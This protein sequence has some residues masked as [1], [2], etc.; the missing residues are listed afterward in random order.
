MVLRMGSKV[1]EEAMNGFRGGCER[2]DFLILLA[3]I[4]VNIGYQWKHV[5]IASSIMLGGERA[6]LAQ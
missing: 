5:V 2:S 1:P 4:I 6:Q 3:C